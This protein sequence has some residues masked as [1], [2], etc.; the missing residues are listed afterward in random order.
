MTGPKGEP[1]ELRLPKDVVFLYEQDG[2]PE[3]ELRDA[4]M[5]YFKNRAKGILRAYLVAARYEKEKV[6]RVVLA[7]R[8]V[9]AVP[10]STIKGA[11]D[12][13]AKIFNAKTSLDILP[14]NE[15]QERAVQQV[16]KAFYVKEPLSRR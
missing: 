12:V 15:K 3:G 13:F 14:I 8:A 11:F 1:E 7:L 2:Q 9:S 6:P 5:D 4:L 16:C 10:F